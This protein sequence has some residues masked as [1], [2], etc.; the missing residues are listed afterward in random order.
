[1]TAHLSD[2]LPL[3]LTGEA[4]RD[5]VLTAAEHLRH[6][7]DCT[8]D[9]VAAVVAHASLTSAQRFAPEIVRN[10]IAVLP[11]ASDAERD[12]PDLS[13]VFAKARL[14]AAAAPLDEQRA[15]RR[16]RA[17]IGAISLGAA[18]A[19]AG[20][21]VTTTV[22]ASDN[23]SS[24]AHHIALAAYG[25][26]HSG[27]SATFTDKSRLRIDATSLPSLDAAHRYEVWLTDAARVR[28]QPVGWIDT[29][30]K[31]DLTVPESLADG[32]QAIEVSVQQVDAS[33]Y[34]YSG[35]SVLRG[36]Y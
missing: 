20:A 4:S 10:A 2:E 12:L 17:K 21:I 29:N 22:V 30:G 11:D 18:A 8:Q 23:A 5:V 27:A 6:C 24:P 28:M 9:L 7:E 32:Y 33:S 36:R 16:R 1:M 15:A 34:A 3:L 13:A 19:V 25:A 14:E 31:A 26:G 35:T